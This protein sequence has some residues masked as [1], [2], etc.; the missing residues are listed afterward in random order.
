M[1]GPDYTGVSDLAIE[2]GDY[3]A[4]MLYA[5]IVQK[6][7]EYFDTLEDFHCIGH[8]VGAHMCGRVGRNFMTYADEMRIGI[9][10]ECHHAPCTS[11]SGPIIPSMG[12]ITALDPA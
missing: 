9:R 8:G 12:R 10:I 5:M 2:L 7:V 3:V 11:E 1:I 6:R 4:N